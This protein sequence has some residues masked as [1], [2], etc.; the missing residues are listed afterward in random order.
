MSLHAR[1]R[2]LENKV[3]ARK[4]DTVVRFFDSEEEYQE[5]LEANRIG[6]NDVSFIEDV[7]KD[8]EREE[9]G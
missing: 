7:P 9:V 4:L 3:A 8:D 6:V 5:A 2:Q 1:L